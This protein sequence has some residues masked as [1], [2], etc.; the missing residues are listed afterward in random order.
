MLKPQGYVTVFGDFQT[1]EYDTITCC[2]CNWVIHVKPGSAST[3]YLIPQ[4]E[5]PPVE[6]MG[7]MCRQCD[8]PVCLR[9]HDLGTC[10]PLMRRI[11]AM[12]GDRLAIARL[13]MG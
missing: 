8:K 2:H 13:G 6:E 4:L 11:E 1:K 10:T 9:C 7:A 3:V 5:G 12:E